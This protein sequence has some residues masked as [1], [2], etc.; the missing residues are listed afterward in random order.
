MRMRGV[1]PPHNNSLSVAPLPVGVHTRL[2]VPYSL[3][4]QAQVKGAI[5]EVRFELYDF[6][7]LSQAPLSAGSLGLL[8]TL[9]R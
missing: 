6:L 2:F 7:I 5:P 1:E 8:T 9:A 3:S 4:F